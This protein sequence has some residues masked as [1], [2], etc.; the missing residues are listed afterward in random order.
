MTTCIIITTPVW[1]N[2]RAAFANNEDRT[3]GN[4]MLS[5]TIELRSISKNIT[6]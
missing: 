2:I 4:L 3:T 5:F 1:M 6:N